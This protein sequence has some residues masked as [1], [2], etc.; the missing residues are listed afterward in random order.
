MGSDNKQK[1]KELL[2]DAERQGW[3]VVPTKRYP[4]MLCPCPEK[5]IK[6][7]VHLTPS[8][9][10]YWLNLRKELARKTCWKEEA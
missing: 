5:H 3:T 6:L 2:D 8:T 4:K 10:T 1:L 9:P 7:S